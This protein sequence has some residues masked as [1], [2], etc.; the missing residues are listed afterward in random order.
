MLAFSYCLNRMSVFLK[1]RPPHKI[2]HNSLFMV[3]I[4]ERNHLNLRTEKKKVSPFP[5]PS[6]FSFPFCSLLFLL[7]F[8]S[9]AVL[10]RCVFC[11]SVCVSLK[12]LLAGRCIYHS[13]SHLA[14]YA[15]GIVHCICVHAQ[16]KRPVTCLERPTIAVSAA[17]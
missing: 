15:Y 13:S 10:S 6:P 17:M 4:D 14:C 5:F 11:L 7:F 12:A 16:L 3:S 8:L 2:L 9:F 1:C